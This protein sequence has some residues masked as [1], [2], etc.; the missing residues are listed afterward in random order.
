MR[1]PVAVGALVLAVAGCG[2]GGDETGSGASVA[3]GVH[4][5]AT[6][7][8]RHDIEATIAQLEGA[9]SRRDAPA[10]C[11]LYTEDARTTETEAYATCATAVRSVLRREKPPRLTIGKIDVSSERTRRPRTL[12][13]SVA[14]TSSAAGRDPF[15][16]DAVLVQ[17]RGMWRVND[18]VSDYLVKPE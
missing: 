11:R 7:P 1:R 9:I 4:R 3:R 2:G 16:L 14:V 10:V 18:A 17:E 5:A 8:E 13:A 12:E 6:V 15:T